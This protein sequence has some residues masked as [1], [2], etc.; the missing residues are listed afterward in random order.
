MQEWLRQRECDYDPRSTKPVLYEIIKG[1]KDK[2]RT[3]EIDTIAAQHGH[4][5]L[6]L[7]PYHCDLNPIDLIWGQIK[8][9]VAKYNTEIKINNTETLFKAAVEKVTA[10]HW[11]RACEH[12]RGIEEFYWKRDGLMDE[13]LDSFVIN[14]EDSGSDDCESDDSECG[15]SSL[16]SP[17]QSATVSLDGISPLPPSP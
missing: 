10:E 6:L 11:R 5:I 17:H 14:L 3:Y 15:D 2:F 1:V 12:V 13:M 7:P 16:L 4:T 8:N 9:D